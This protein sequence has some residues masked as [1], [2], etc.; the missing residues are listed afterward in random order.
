MALR[1]RLVGTW[2]MVDNVNTRAGVESRPF[3]A[4]P[5]GQLML[6]ADGYV[7]V[8]MFRPDL[9][10]FEAGNRLHGTA[11]ENSRVVQGC[12]AVMGTY[13]LL[14]AESTLVLVARASTYPNLVGVPVRRPFV[15]EGDMQTWIVPEATVG[16][17]SKIV[18]RRAGAQA[19]AA[20]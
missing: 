6:D 20:E 11:E 9:P 10:R 7:S 18:W 5:V 14:G 17:H 19:Y 15:L 16:G 12:L 4:P 2:R 13:E 8:L 1:D 3:G